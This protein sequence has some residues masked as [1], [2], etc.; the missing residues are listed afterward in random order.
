M[1]YN[2]P[3]NAGDAGMP[4]EKDAQIFT[5]GLQKTIFVSGWPIAPCDKSF[6]IK[7]PTEVQ[8]GHI[9]SNLEKI[10]FSYKE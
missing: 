7:P 9:F 8:L 1:V 6:K 10:K 2:G 5:G 3:L 4:E